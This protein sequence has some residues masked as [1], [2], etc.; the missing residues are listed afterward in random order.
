MKKLTFIALLALAMFPS[1]AFAQARF[2]GIREFI[3]SAGQLVKLAIPVVAG[4]A[5]LVFFWGLVKF[6]YA[7]SAEGKSEGKNF[8]LWGIIALFV[9][10]AVWGL[11]YFIIEQLN[12]P[13]YLV[14]PRV[15]SLQ[16]P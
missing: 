13:G 10:I 6:I 8:M 11:V 9:M 16:I 12:L 2:G 14:D 5:L 7:S 4:I 15:P 3:T 1:V